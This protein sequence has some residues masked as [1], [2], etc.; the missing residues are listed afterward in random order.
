M[1]IE[2]NYRGLRRLATFEERFDYLSLRSEVGKA[3]FGFERYMNQ[4]FYQ[5]REWKQVRD[6]VIARDEGC[7]LGIP[8]YEIFDRIIIHHIKPMT[9]EDVEYAHPSILDPDNLISTT[10]NTH[11]AIHFG[12]E[13]LL[14]KPFKERQPGDTRLW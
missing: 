11:N 12:D 14:V 9:V 10:H 4:R 13:S 6:K 2:R 8:G 7:D 3:T 5:S 1:A